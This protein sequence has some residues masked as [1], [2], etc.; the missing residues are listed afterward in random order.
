MRDLKQKAIRSQIVY[1]GAI[2]N[3]RK[4]EAVMANDRPVSREV[5][6]HYGGAAVAMENADG[7]FFMVRQW[8]YAYRGVL[9]EYPAGKKEA[10][11]DA[12]VTAKREIREETGYEGENW[13]YLGRMVPTPAY[14]EE[15]IDLFYATCG[16]YRGQ[17]LD[18]DEELDVCRMPLAAIRKAIMDGE[19]ID[20]KT[21]ALT[22]LVQEKIRKGKEI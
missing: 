9:L 10:D 21:I 4:D 5:V 13:L 7:T 8:R 12:L 17:R 6:E 11:E 1:Q 16:A 19:I 22:Y 3:V 14:D 18:V 2:F 15:V 20:A